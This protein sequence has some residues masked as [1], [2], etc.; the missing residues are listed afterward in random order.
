MKI[1]IAPCS[2]KGTF[3]TLEVIEI[4]EEQA[5]K[6][7]K[8]AYIKGVPIADGGE[9]TVHALVNF[10]KGEY[11]YARITGP[12]GKP[13]EA[14]YG[15]INEDTAVLEVAQTSGLKVLEKERTGLPCATTYGM[16]ELIKHVLDEGFR[17]ITIGLGGSGTN[18]GGIGMAQAMGVRFILQDGT[19]ARF[20]GR[21]LDKISDIDISGLDERIQDCEIIVMCDVSNPLTGESGATYIFGGQKGGDPAMLD[22]LEAGMKHYARIVK[23]KLGLYLNAMPGGGAAGGLGAALA[24]FLDARLKVGTEY[25]LNMIGFEE[26]IKDADLVVTGE[27]KLDRSTTFGKAPV[28]IAHCCARYEVPVAVVA[29]SL[30]P[31]YERMYEYGIQ[32]VMPSVASVMTDDEM[33]CN[34]RQDLMM[35]SD[36]LFRLI[37]LGMHI[38]NK[39]Y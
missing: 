38:K 28:G 18:D 12:A 39:N 1:V 14:L 8:N 16:G 27:G 5:R 19:E 2:F 23:E 33:V 22:C 4:V 29:G 11:R 30:G 7:F 20:G 24:G 17:K 36:R 21:D 13:V 6:H 32:G 31:G 15:V 10:T 35:A 34:A 25:F 9:G 26:I 3:S 37:K